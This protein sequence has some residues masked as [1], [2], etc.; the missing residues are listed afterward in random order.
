MYFIS[1]YI[2]TFTPFMVFFIQSSLLEEMTK[3]PFVAVK[4]PIV[5]Q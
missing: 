5:F 4:W 3:L 1:L 2:I